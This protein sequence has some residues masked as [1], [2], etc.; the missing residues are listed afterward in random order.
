MSFVRQIGAPAINLLKKTH[1]MGVLT[2]ISK[3]H[4]KVSFIYLFISSLKNILQYL[5]LHIM[6]CNYHNKYN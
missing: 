1:S 4:E 5:E 2:Q 6:T 3:Y